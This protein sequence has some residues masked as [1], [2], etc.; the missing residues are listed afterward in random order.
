MPEKGKARPPRVTK[1]VVSGARVR[2]VKVLAAMLPGMVLKVPAMRVGMGSGKRI[3]RRISVS[4]RVRPARSSDSEGPF[5][6]S[7]PLAALKDQR[8]RPMGTERASGDWTRTV[9]S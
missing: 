7:H 4:G 8:S 9:K 3:M 2:T 6:R 1:V 5:M